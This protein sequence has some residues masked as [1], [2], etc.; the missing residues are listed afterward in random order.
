MFLLDVGSSPSA[1]ALLALVA[2]LSTLG[3]A[4]AL[5]LRG[6]PAEM[7]IEDIPIGRASGAGLLGTVKV[8]N[9]GGEP[10]EVE[11]S[12]AAAGPGD[13]IDGYELAKN[14]SWVKLVKPKLKIAPGAEGE[15]P[16]QIA[17]P[18]DH[19]LLGGQ[20]QLEWVGEAKGPDGSK[21]GLHSQVLLNVAPHDEEMIALARRRIRDKAALVFELSSRSGKAEAVPLGRKVDLRS[22]GVK[23]KLINANAQAVTFAVFPAKEALDDS[24]DG[25]EDG[26]AEPGF[27]PSPNPNFLTL[28]SPVVQVPADGIGEAQI[29]LEIPDQKRYR[30][31]RW[32]FDVRVELL[33]ADKPTARDFRLTVKTQGDNM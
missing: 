14:L 23:L 28:A 29:F 19:D 21:L 17:L 32:V 1:W 8:A 33:E 12:L 25:G 27:S 5:A 2:L 16:L 4:H 15:S 20:F 9:T 30:G 6:P 7:S 18:K 26:I 24:Q 13:L 11:M 22:L 10:I 3:Q 31:R